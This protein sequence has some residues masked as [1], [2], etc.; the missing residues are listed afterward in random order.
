VLKIKKKILLKLNK[1]FE[2]ILFFLLKTH[3][4]LFQL[5]FLQTK[6][7][8]CISNSMISSIF[9]AVSI[10][11]EELYAIRVILFVHYLVFI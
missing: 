8:A 1:G 10:Y 11:Y 7:F 5:P 4:P 6:L 3:Q 2:I 9:E